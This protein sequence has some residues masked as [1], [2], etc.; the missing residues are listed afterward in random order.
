[1]KRYIIIAIRDYPDMPVGHRNSYIVGY[2]SAENRA[3]GI[4]ENEVKL[5]GGKYGCIVLDTETFAEICAIGRN[6]K[7]QN[8]STDEI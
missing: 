7:I 1:M 8:K 4:A 3:R 2:E 5:R 6:E